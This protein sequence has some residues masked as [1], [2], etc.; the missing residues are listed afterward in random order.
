AG[1]SDAFQGVAYGARI[2][3]LKAADAHGQT[4]LA[5]IVA[6][7]KWVT[8]HAHDNG[9]NIRVLNLSFGA[10]ASSGYRK[11]DLAYAVERAWSAGIAVVVAA[12]NEGIGSNGLDT[13]AFDPYVIAVG[14]D[15]AHGT[16][17]ISDDNVGVFSS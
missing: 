6:E 2:V 11:D 16:T 10:V 8:Q 15:N 1:H 14:A 17:D 5:Q 3:S 7:I 13:P 4:D 12:G 9:M